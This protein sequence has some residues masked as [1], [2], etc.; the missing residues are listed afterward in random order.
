MQGPGALN[1]RELED[2]EYDRIEC[3]VRDSCDALQR[4]VISDDI[5][6]LAQALK[7][8]DALRKLKQTELESI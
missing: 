5:E 7:L 6:F 3:L 8:T 4:Y 2:V 1:E